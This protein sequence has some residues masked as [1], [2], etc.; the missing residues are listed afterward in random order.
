MGTTKTFYQIYNR[1]FSRSELEEI[2]KMAFSVKTSNNFMFSEMFEKLA[3][4]EA[5]QQ[6]KKE[7]LSNKNIIDKILRVSADVSNRMSPTI[8]YNGDSKWLPYFEVDICEGYNASH[9]DTER[10][11][12]IF[13]S[14]VLAFSVFDSDILFV[15]YSDYVSNISY[16]YARPNSDGFDEYDTSLYKTDFPG[17]LLDFLTEGQKDDFRVIWDGEEVFAEDRMMKILKLLQAVPF[18]D[19]VPDGFQA[20]GRSDG[21]MVLDKLQ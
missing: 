18:F 16:D 6:M 4:S 5:G 12:K 15:S 21:D 19:E 1:G 14:P 17:F 7:I 2:M 10:L 13:G 11:S 8:M 9:R 20:I 3:F